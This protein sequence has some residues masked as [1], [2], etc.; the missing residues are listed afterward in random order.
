M[1]S[2]GMP[3]KGPARGFRHSTARALADRRNP[4]PACHHRHRDRP[5][6]RSRPQMPPLLEIHSVIRDGV[7]LEAR[8][9]TAAPWAHG[10]SSG[11][12]SSS[13]ARRFPRLRHPG[14]RGPRGSH[15]G[16]PGDPDR[17]KRLLLRQGQYRRRG[18]HGIFD[19][20]L[21]ARSQLII[22]STGRVNGK[23]RY[24]VLVAHEGCELCGDVSCVLSD[25]TAEKKNL[26]LESTATVAVAGM[27]RRSG[28]KRSARL[29]RQ[30]L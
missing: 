4:L 10:S 21:T 25:R 24:G 20:E 2:S 23:I 6:H 9:P 5:P 27:A 29:Y 19:G 7:A 13:K 14:R 11:P 26:S 18:I 22:H 3:G 12:T 8:R 28:Q 1:S 17:R 30:V 16:Q 15:H